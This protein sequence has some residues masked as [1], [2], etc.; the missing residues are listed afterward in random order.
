MRIKINFS[1]IKQEEINDATQYEEISRND[2][3][4]QWPSAIHTTICLYGMRVCV[5]LHT[6]QA[7]V[8][9]MYVF[10]LPCALHTEQSILR[11]GLGKCI[12]VEAGDCDVGI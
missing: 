2:G 9:L 1:W 11:K 4:I 5:S 7:T 3:S 6:Y 10:K 12:V 8:S